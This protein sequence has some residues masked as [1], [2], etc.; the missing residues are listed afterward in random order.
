[1]VDFDD[2]LVEKW[3]ENGIVMPLVMRRAAGAVGL[4]KLKNHL[5]VF[6]SAIA[7]GIA[8]PAGAAPVES[9]TITMTPTHVLEFDGGSRFDPG[10]VPKGYWPRLI[11]SLAASTQ[12]EEDGPD[13]T[14]PFA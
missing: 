6:A 13:D 5:S 7:M 3:H 8:L 11:K 10:D 4:T 2:R 1:M 14:E 12:L 9:A